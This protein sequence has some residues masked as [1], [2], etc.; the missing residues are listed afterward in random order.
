[1]RIDGPKNSGLPNLAAQVPVQSDRTKG[2]KADI[3]PGVQ[4]LP[5]HA[6]YL[7]AFKSTPEVN[8]QAVAEAKRL[9][10]SGELDTLDAIKRAAIAIVD[11]GI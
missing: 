10:N 9:I 11:K 4:V 1:V 2:H 5:S 8:A 3:T 6:K 7:Q